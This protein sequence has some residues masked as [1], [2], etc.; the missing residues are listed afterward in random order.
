MKT[1]DR[2][3][4]R[5]FTCK[6]LPLLAVLTVVACGGGNEQPEVSQANVVALSAVDGWQLGIHTTGTGDTLTL[7]ID[8]VDYVPK[9]R[10]MVAAGTVQTLEVDS[11]DGKSIYFGSMRQPQED[12]LPL[13]GQAYLVT[14]D[15]ASSFPWNFAAPQ[16]AKAPSDD[17]QGRS[18]ALGVKEWWAKAIKMAK[19]GNP[20]S[21]IKLYLEG[22]GYVCPPGPWFLCARRAS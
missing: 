1:I 2:A 7:T 13:T 5:A 6:L 8:G 16:A 4:K 9:L 15:G 18:T 22:K 20:N 3:P 19:L 10:H 17:V 11:E 12:G 21:L 14:N